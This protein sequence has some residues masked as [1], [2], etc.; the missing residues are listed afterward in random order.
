M[1]DDTQG[2]MSWADAWQ[3]LVYR[4]TPFRAVG[5]EEFQAL[6]QRV[7]DLERLFLEDRDLDAYYT[8]QRASLP[9]DVERRLPLEKIIHVV[10]IQLQIMEDAFFSLRLDRHANAPDNR[11]WLNLFRRWS[12][13]RM[14]QEYADQLAETFSEHFVAFY[15]QYIKGW[16][17]DIPVPHPWDMQVKAEDTP[18]LRATKDA[19]VKC[20]SE[21]WPSAKR[22]KGVFLD[23]G[24]VEAGRH[25][26]YEPLTVRERE[27]GK[28][29]NASLGRSATGA[30]SAGGGVEDSSKTTD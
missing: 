25:G 30:P 3:E 10:A 8:S 26:A 1:A 12:K 29:P 19:L 2:G 4:H 7:T 5:N 28:E 23:P 22:G 11:G 14:F 20:Q 17:A 6:L 16:E 9:P 24:R 13:G 21:A 18:F 15:E 27:H